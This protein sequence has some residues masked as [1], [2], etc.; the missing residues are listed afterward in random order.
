MQASTSVLVTLD[1][2][3]RE[4][5]ET[6]TIP[7]ITSE[8]RCLYFSSVYGRSITRVPWCRPLQRNLLNSSKLSHIPEFP[9]FWRLKGNFILFYFS[10]FMD[11]IFIAGVEILPQDSLIANDKCSMWHSHKKCMLRSHCLCTFHILQQRIKLLV[12]ISQSKWQHFF[13][14][15]I[16][17]R[18]DVLLLSDMV[19]E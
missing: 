2:L 5:R 10:F 16:C 4:W 3:W 18:S 15:L 19:K 1:P 14:L 11:I 7:F 6:S 13:G 12:S 9:N 8:S 17:F